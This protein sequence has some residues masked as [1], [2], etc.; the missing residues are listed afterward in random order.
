MT[1]ALILASNLIGSRLFRTLQGWEFFSLAPPCLTCQGNIYS[2]K[3]SRFAHAVTHEDLLATF[4]LPGTP[5]P[6]ADWSQ[7][8]AERGIKVEGP[9]DRQAGLEMLRAAVQ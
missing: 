8:L 3:P 7:Q 1:N 6:K 5:F 4:A 2:E 9:I